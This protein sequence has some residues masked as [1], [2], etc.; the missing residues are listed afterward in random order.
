MDVIFTGGGQWLEVL[1]KLGHCHDHIE[2]MS[3]I[4]PIK[5]L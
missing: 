2:A 3:L 5:R 1:Y 4:T